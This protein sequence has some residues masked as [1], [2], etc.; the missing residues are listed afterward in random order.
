MSESSDLKRAGLKATLPRLRILEVFEQAMPRHLSPEDVY[1]QLLS[2]NIEVGLATVYRV[3]AQLQQAGLLRLARFDAGKA[4]YELDDGSHHDHLVCTECGWVEEF[5]DEVIEAHQRRVAMRLGFELG[6]H[7]LVLYGRC[8][9]VD[10]EHR[11]HME[12]RQGC[13]HEH[14]R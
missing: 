4:M 5:H 11:H 2:R 10:C 13:K 3:L 1:R 8:T 6:D 7:T 12:S 9:K 14:F